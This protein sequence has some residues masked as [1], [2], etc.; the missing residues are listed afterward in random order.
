[1][2]VIK[3]LPR[4]LIMTETWILQPFLSLLTV[5]NSLKKDSYTLEI[6]AILILALTVW[7]LQNM[8]DGLQWMQE[9]LMAMGRLIWSLPIFPSPLQCLGRKLIGPNNPNSCY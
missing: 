8:E 9:I 2:G 4:I 1:M 3:L 7:K 6:T 5:T